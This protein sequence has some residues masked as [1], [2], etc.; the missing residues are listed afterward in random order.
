[1]TV[2]TKNERGAE[3]LADRKT[4]IGKQ[5][6]AFDRYDRNGDFVLERTYDGNESARSIWTIHR[7]DDE[8]S[9]LTIEATLSMGP[10]R[11]V[12]MKPALK[13]LF[14]GINFTRSS[15]RPN[16]APRL[17]RQPGCL[18]VVAPE[19]GLRPPRRTPRGR[20]PMTRPLRDERRVRD[21][22][23]TVADQL[24]TRADP[25]LREHF[26]KV[27]LD[28][29]RAEKELR[30]D[31]PVRVS[32]ADEHRELQFLCAAVLPIR[33]RTRDRGDRRRCSA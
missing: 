32:F 14:C 16:A 25:E 20:R 2:V 13:H 3:F 4:K 23:D 30:G 26:A 28:R 17:R 31:V 9:T 21:D 24:R 11:G 33:A 27:I 8:N 1:V 18:T 19:C 29:S 12:L 22:A 7:I 6:R 5:V 15:R 10:V